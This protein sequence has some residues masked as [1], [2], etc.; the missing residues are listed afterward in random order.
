[1]EKEMVQWL[2]ALAALAE[3]PG[4]IPRTYIV[5]HNDCNS[6]SKEYYAIYLSI[7]LFAL[8]RH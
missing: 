8:R 6:N 5:T 3:E 2:K 1:M 4:L 7:Y